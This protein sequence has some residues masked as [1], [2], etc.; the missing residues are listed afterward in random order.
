MSHFHGRFYAY[1][2][3]SLHLWEKKKEKVWEG[4]HQKLPNHLTFCWHLPFHNINFRYAEKGRSKVTRKLLRFLL[5]QSTLVSTLFLNEYQLWVFSKLS[6]LFTKFTNY[7][8]YVY[9]LVRK[10]FWS[11]F[12]IVLHL[13]SHLI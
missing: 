7:P 2:T 11:F 10:I 3:L 4:C 8:M 13:T 12:S 6:M 5:V 1:L 9:V